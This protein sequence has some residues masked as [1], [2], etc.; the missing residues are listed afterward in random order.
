MKKSL[1]WIVVLLCTALFAQ[2]PVFVDQYL[3]RLEG[4]LAENL[5]QVDAYI[6]VAKDGKKTLDQYIAKF[7]AQPDTDFSAQG[8]VMQATVSR[9]AFLE[10]AC[11]ALRSSSP[12]VRPIVFVRYLD[13][14]TFADTWNG[15]TPG[16]LVDTNLVV[17]ALIG[18]ASGWAML[19]AFSGFWN[20]LRGR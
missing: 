16:L 18:F 14:Q 11:E 15:F 3:M 7:L 1:R 6:K 13:G 4:R 10:E 19:Y 17:W 2:V 12:L 8:K 5:L 9:K 20:L